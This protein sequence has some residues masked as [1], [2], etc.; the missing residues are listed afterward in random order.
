MLGLLKK[1]AE[2]F[3]VCPA[4]RLYHHAYLGG[5]LEHTWFLARMA[6]QATAIYAH[7]NRNLVLAGIILHDIGK[8]KEITTPHAPEYSISGQLLGHI[9]LG[10]E[11]VREEAAAQDFP[12][13]HLLLQ[14][15]HIIVSHHGYHEFGSPVLPKTREALLVY[16]LDDLDAKLKMMDQHLE[17]DSGDRDF[18]SYN[19]LLQRQ[20][21]KALEYP[22]T[23]PAD[24]GLAED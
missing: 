23:A 5:L 18:T 21:Y 19:R 8:V 20:L 4:A 14:L 17:V 6:L 2:T 10:L 16:Y 11:M 7:L 9:I 1:H 3:K 22:E 12:D 15:E 24:P 13:P